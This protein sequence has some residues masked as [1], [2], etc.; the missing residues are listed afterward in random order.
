VLGKPRRAEHDAGYLGEKLRP[1][2]AAPDELAD[3]FVPRGILRGVEVDA[4]V[5]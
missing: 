3:R 2:T 1:V 4:V 5:L